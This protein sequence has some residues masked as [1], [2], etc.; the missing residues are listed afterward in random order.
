M[1]DIPNNITLYSEII[2]LWN[3][4]HGFFKN[5]RECLTLWKNSMYLITG[6]ADPYIVI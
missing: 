4:V 3:Y 1:T 6:R 2:T 5:S